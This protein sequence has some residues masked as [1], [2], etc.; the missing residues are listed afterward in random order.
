MFN[1]NL[2]LFE[3]KTNKERIEDFKSVSVFDIDTNCANLGVH[4]NTQKINNQILF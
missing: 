4:L 2:I 1:A 3:L